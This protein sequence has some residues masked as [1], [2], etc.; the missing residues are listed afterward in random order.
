MASRKKLAHEM[1]SPMTQPM[2]QAEFTYRVNRLRLILLLIWG[3]I[4]FGVAFFA[5]DLSFNVLDKPF[6]FWMAAQ[7]SLLIFLAITWVYA[8]L[9]NRWER[10]TE[11]E[12]SPES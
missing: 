6:G 8:L 4:T 10:L 2:P 12:T 3:S 7:G 9:V 5:R 11:T 1:M